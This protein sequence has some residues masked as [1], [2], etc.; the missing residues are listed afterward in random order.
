MADRHTP[1]PWFVRD[2][3]GNNTKEITRINLRGNHRPLA[4]LGSGSVNREADARLIAAAPDLFEALM[5]FVDNPGLSDT[6]RQQKAIAAVA[7]ATA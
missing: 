1:G 6:E 5:A 3:N 2:G 7:K 4:R